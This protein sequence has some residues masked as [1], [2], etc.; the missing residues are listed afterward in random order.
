MELMLKSADGRA[1]RA[2]WRHASSDVKFAVE[3]G[4]GT[5]SLVDEAVICQG[6]DRIWTEK[7]VRMAFAREGF[8]WV[9]LRFQF[10][11]RADGVCQVYFPE[12]FQKSLSFGFFGTRDNPGWVG[13]SSIRPDKEKHLQSPV[14]RLDGHALSNE[15]WQKLY[16]LNEQLT[17]WGSLENRGFHD[18]LGGKQVGT[19]I[20]LAVIGEGQTVT[21]DSLSRGCVKGSI[22]P[23]LMVG[24]SVCWPFRG[25][26][27]TGVVSSFTKNGVRIKTDDG[28]DSSVA[29]ACVQPSMAQVVVPSEIH[30]SISVNFSD[31]GKMVQFL[32]RAS[33]KVVDHITIPMFPTEEQGERKMS[34]DNCI[35]CTCPLCGWQMVLKPVSYCDHVH[36]LECAFCRQ[37][38]LLISRSESELV[39]RLNRLPAKNQF[40]IREAKCCGNCGLFQFESGREGKRS[41]GYC[42]R[43]YQCLQA[44]NVCDW[45]FPREP[46]RYAQGMKQHCTNLGYGVA[47]RRN[48]T[49]NELRDVVYTADD[50]E[51][52]K[53]RAETAKRMY[54]A[55]YRNLLDGLRLAGEALPLIGD[56]VDDDIKSKYLKVLEG[57]VE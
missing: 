21:P 45:W 2:R 28:K 13:L 11:Y 57:G 4:D 24:D 1:V 51:N 49:R 38:A 22:R 37:T 43:S 26:Q 53:K 35:T 39:G 48:T 5:S 47:D 15:E 36:E 30:A 27:R 55:G 7:H 23:R 20:I 9:Q 6:D 40:A 10:D 3:N 46:D 44:H 12:Y 14:Y 33:V 52:Q 32:F 41:T 54:V 34:F 17:S 25:N 8:N 31:V 42:R 19:D 50:H 16:G 29:F 18:M 56:S